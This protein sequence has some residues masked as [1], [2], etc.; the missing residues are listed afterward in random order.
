MDLT[1]RVRL[2][3]PPQ[4]V[5]A[6]V[7]DPVRL[8]ALVPG[9]SVDEAA[10]DTFAG[11]FRVKLGPSLLTLAGEGRY[12]RRD[13]AALRAVLETTGTDRR[14]DAGVRGRHTLTLAGA[15]GG[16][17][18]DVTVETTMTWTGRPSR[19]GEGVVVDAVDRALDQVGTR[20][21][22]RVAEGLPWAPAAEDAV[23]DDDERAAAVVDHPVALGADLGAVDQPEPGRTARPT[24]SP[25]PGP[26]PRPQPAEYVYKPFSNAAEPHVTA[27][28]TLSGLAR[29][30]VVPYAGLGVLAVF[31]AVSAV[32][33]ARR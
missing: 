29:R 2:P 4:E 3:A 14:G 28:R 33:R 23:D 18:T 12:V 21:A 7:C 9:S 11:R 16:T 30:H 22:A 31:V 6:A 5:W 19:L 20:A 32:R 13:D 15:D 27:V 17:S 24:P 1:H 10:D 26:S 8:A 25:S